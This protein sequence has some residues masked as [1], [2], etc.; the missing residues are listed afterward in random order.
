MVTHIQLTSDERKELKQLIKTGQ[1]PVRVVARARI[2]LLLDQSKGQYR[3][4]QAVAEAM[5]TSRT[6]VHTVKKRYLTGGLA[7]ALYDQK[8][9]P[10]KPLKMT[11]DVEAQLV[12][13]TCSPPPA[14][15][16][17]WTLRLLAEK[18][19]ELEVV[20]Y[21]SHVTVGETLKKMNSN[22]GE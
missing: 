7:K 17:R 5:M 4:M 12:A 22:R 19:I 16:Q 3:T 21:I 1:Q 2:L 13:L 6:T 10:A 18:L 20:E 14:D 11:G 15:H 9:P 8:G